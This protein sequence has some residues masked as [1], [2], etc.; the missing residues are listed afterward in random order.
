MKFTPFQA[1]ARALTEL[2]L[3]VFLYQELF[4]FPPWKEHDDNLLGVETWTRNPNLKVE[5]LNL[6]QEESFV[7]PGLYLSSTSPGPDHEASS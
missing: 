6:L 7:L 1:M 2:F 3:P 4:F 5:L